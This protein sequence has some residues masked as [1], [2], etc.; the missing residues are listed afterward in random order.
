MMWIAKSMQLA[1]TPLLRCMCGVAMLRCR[2]GVAMLRCM[3][4]AAMFFE[5]AG[6]TAGHE[7][8]AYFFLCWLQKKNASS[9]KLKKACQSKLKK[10][11]FLAL[12]WKWPV[13]FFFYKKAYDI[14]KKVCECIFRPFKIPIGLIIDI[15]TAL[16]K[17]K[18]S[19]RENIPVMCFEIFRS[20]HQ[21]VF[22]GIHGYEVGL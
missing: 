18:L 9:I 3:C 4:G 11:S 8:W 13:C 7:R 5:Q 21:S 2:C 14:H 20:K 15:W 10:I 19:S 22:H 17:G 16:P 12:S 6:A 1:I